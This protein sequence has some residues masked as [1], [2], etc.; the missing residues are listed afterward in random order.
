MR[1]T[2]ELLLTEEGSPTERNAMLSRIRESTIQAAFSARPPK[3]N[4]HPLRSR[5]ASQARRR[6]FASNRLKRYFTMLRPRFVYGVAALLVGVAVEVETTGFRLM[7]YPWN[8]RADRGDAQIP[9]AGKPFGPGLGMKAKIM[10]FTTI[11]KVRTAIKPKALL[12]HL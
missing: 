9:E 11:K 6:L 5:H 7:P 12:L 3:K 1:H 10:H 8:V 2:H 4:L